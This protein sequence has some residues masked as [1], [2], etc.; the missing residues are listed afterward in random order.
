MFPKQ[1]KRKFRLKS[2]LL[3][4][5]TGGAPTARHFFFIFT[6]FPLGT[7]AARWFLLIF[8]LARLRHANFLHFPL[9][10]AFRFLPYGQFHYKLMY[11][12]RG[13]AP[14]FFSY[15]W[16]VF[17]KTCIFCVS[18]LENYFATPKSIDSDGFDRTNDQKLHFPFPEHF[19]AIVAFW[20]DF[21]GF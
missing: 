9:Y 17:W 6:Y 12:S 18:E 14:R 4:F 16:F 2:L 13:C 7:P 1:L 3:P 21:L 15:F 10:F 20:K 11:Q 8:P 5:F 19:W